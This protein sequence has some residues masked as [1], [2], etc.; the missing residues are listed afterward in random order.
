MARRE[1][2][3]PGDRVSVHDSVQEMYEHIHR[4][5]LSN[6]WDRFGPQEKIRCIS[7]CPG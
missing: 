4:D 2:F 6:V 7:A 3:R 5:G 1:G